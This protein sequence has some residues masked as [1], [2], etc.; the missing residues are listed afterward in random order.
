MLF[1][2]LVANTFVT[3]SINVA[4]ISM[5]RPIQQEQ[6]THLNDTKNVT[7]SNAT[8][9]EFRNVKAEVISDSDIQVSWSRKSNY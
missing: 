1:F 7:R 5:V 6:D 3:L 9:Y 8:F 4:I 2:L